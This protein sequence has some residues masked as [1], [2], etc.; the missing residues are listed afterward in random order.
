MRLLLF[1]HIFQNIFLK[2][3]ELG[4]VP[5]KTGFVDRKIF[6]Q[7]GQFRFAFHG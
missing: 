2:Q 5:E 1:Q 7:L 3:I 6:H 4:L